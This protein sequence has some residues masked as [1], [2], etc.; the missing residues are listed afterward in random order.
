MSSIILKEHCGVLRVL[1]AITL[2][3]G[4]TILS[5]PPAL[6]PVLPNNH[7]HDHGVPD[8]DVCGRYDDDDGGYDDDDDGGYDAI[9]VVS[10]L[11][12]PILS[13]WICIITW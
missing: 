9:G 6:F 12:V 11:A 13:A 5:R 1:V 10:A 3:A 7:T 8:D 2:L 4:V